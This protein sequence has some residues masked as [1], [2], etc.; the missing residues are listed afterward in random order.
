MRP[1]AL[2][3]NV[4]IGPPS[5]PP[6]MD[7]LGPPGPDFDKMDPPDVIFGPPRC[8]IWTPHT[9]QFDTHHMTIMTSQYDILY[10]VY[11]HGDW[12]LPMVIISVY[13][14][15][16]YTWQFD[17]HHLRLYSVYIGECI[18]YQYTIRYVPEESPR[19]YVVHT[20]CTH[21]L[22]NTIAYMSTMCG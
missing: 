20:K 13:H 15:G 17:T 22:P 7:I 19:R 3:E 1:Q 2:W 10:S 18:R 8:H 4:Q 11:H 14:S 6:Q 9:W 16:T 12:Q 21:A 5:R